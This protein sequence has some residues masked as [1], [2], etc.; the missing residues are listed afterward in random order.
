MAKPM[1]KPDFTEMFTFQRVITGGADPCDTCEYEGTEGYP[2]YDCCSTESFYK[3]PLAEKDL[4][5]TE[6]V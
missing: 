2:C 4:G 1:A 6:W 5:K 3:G